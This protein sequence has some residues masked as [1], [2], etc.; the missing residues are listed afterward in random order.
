MPQSIQALNESRKDGLQ[1]LN[2]HF[3]TSVINVTISLHY[4]IEYILGLY[5]VIM[6]FPSINSADKNSYFSKD[7]QVI[8]ILL[9]S[10]HLDIA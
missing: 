2:T 1:Q 5:H 7:L 9:L 10:G 6:E 4:V 8:I 3:K